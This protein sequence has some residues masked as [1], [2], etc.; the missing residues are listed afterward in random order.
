ML[1]INPGLSIWVLIVP[2]SLWIALSVI[3]ANIAQKKGRPWHLFFLLSLLAPFIGLII[4]IVLS[5]E[6]K[7]AEVHTKLENLAQLAKLKDSGAITEDEYTAEKKK[8]LG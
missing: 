3:A 1:D 6:N 4:A 2:L 5:P 7:E 8:I